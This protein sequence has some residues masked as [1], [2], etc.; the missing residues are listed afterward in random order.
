MK[1]VSND[2][3]YEADSILVFQ[4]VYFLQASVTG[5]PGYT[6]PATSTRSLGPHQDLDETYKL[7]QLRAS[8]SIARQLT[9]AYQLAANAA[10]QLQRNI[11]KIRC[12]SIRRLLGPGGA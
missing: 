9:H 3:I 4:R 1:M 2:A 12:Q 11:A 7:S 8:T 6:G 5:N 10:V